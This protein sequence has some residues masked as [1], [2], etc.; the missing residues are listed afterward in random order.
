MEVR[1]FDILAFLRRNVVKCKHREERFV[2]AFILNTLYDYQLRNSRIF[3]YIWVDLNDSVLDLNDVQKY[4]EHYC[5]ICENN[6]V[7]PELRICINMVKSLF[8]ISCGL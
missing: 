6:F 7:A 3:S 8:T 2:S 5:A 4:I 1:Y